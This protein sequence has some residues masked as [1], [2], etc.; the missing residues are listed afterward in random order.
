MDKFNAFRQSIQ[1]IT[2]RDELMERKGGWR[3]NDTIAHRN[4]SQQSSV[5][6]HSE[7]F[8]FVGVVENQYHHFDGAFTCALHTLQK[9]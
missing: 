9:P 5:H 8:V 4:N 7:V 3:Q 1:E 2:A 6:I